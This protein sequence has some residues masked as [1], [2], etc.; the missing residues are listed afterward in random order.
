MPIGRFSSSI[1]E[2]MRRRRGPCRLVRGRR[3]GSADG[4]PG[5]RHR[6]RAMPSRRDEP[7]PDEPGRIGARVEPAR[8]ADLRRPHRGGVRDDAVRGAARD[9]RSTRGRTVGAAVTAVTAFCR[10]D[11]SIA[12]F[13][14]GPSRRG[15]AIGGG[16]V[17]VVAADLPLRE[18]LRRHA[19]RQRPSGRRAGGVRVRFAAQRGARASGRPGPR[20]RREQHVRRRHD[21]DDRGERRGRRVSLVGGDD[22]RTRSPG[23][24][25][26]VGRD[27]GLVAPAT[28]PR[29]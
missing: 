10:A 11:P 22:R 5:P 2:A 25:A 19:L 9:R 28:S 24:P 3:T 6:S 4:I 16:I 21:P 20:D 23:A 7:E 26:A 13:A 15:S 1:A 27:A 8:P 18:Q 17:A 12:R 29:A 14:R